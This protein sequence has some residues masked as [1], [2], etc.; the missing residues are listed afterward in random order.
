M[1]Q[2][3]PFGGAGDAKYWNQIPEWCL[4][5]R[6]LQCR[7]GNEQK[8]HS[9]VTAW[10]AF[11]FPPFTTALTKSRHE[12][13]KELCTKSSLLDV[14]KNKFCDMQNELYVS[15]GIPS[16]S[17]QHVNKQQTGAKR[18]RQVLMITKACLNASINCKLQ[19]VCGDG[20]RLWFAWWMFS[21]HYTRG[22]WGRACIGLLWCTCSVHL[23]V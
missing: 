8:E 13:L 3:Q 23:V 10:P 9:S 12:T 2:Q 14:R 7:L 19:D 6:Q 18:H 4:L 11:I 5:K 20:V 1:P 17:L 16:S 22:N 15:C 21:A